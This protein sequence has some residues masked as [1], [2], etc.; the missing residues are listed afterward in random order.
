MMSLKESD[1]DEVAGL[2]KERSDL[3]AAFNAGTFQ[4]KLDITFS[5]TAFSE[6]RHI[7]HW[8]TRDD[9]LLDHESNDLMW[10]LL[11]RRVTLI[12]ERLAEIGV[13]VI[14]DENVV[15]AQAGTQ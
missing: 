14:K 8:L 13:E 3:L 1:I 15:P 5:P 9:A 7:E 11:R 6:D 4:I 2:L 10:R 12:D